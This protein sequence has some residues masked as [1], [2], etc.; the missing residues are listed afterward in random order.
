MVYILFFLLFLSTHA[1][2]IVGGSE[3]KTKLMF[4]MYDIDHSGKLSRKEFSDMIR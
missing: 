3:E 1:I 4:D 2:V